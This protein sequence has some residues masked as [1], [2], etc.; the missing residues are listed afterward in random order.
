MDSHTALYP[1][2]SPTNASSTAINPFII[3]SPTED[4]DVETQSFRDSTQLIPSPKQRPPQWVSEMFFRC[5]L[6]VCG[7][8]LWTRGWVVMLFYI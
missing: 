7:G 6:A 1:S 5:C 2:R 8:E 3:I 4:K